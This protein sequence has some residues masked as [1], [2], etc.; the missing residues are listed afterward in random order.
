MLFSITIITITLFSQKLF[1]IIKKDEFYSHS[2]DLLM[3]PA[4]LRSK[5]KHI[6]FTQKCNPD[7]LHAATTCHTRAQLRQVIVTIFTGCDVSIKQF[8]FQ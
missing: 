7:L 8:S 2:I 5:Y 6:I 4:M 3:N 1:F